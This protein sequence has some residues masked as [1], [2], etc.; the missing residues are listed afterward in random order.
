MTRRPTHITP[1]LAIILLMISCGKDDDKI[2]DLVKYKIS[3]HLTDLYQYDYLGRVI[4]MDSIYFYTYSDSMVKEF[5]E[6]GPHGAD[7]QI[8]HYLNSEGLVYKSV[9]FYLERPT[10]TASFYIDY[11]YYDLNGHLIE[12]SAYRGYVH[13]YNHRYLWE[14]GNIKEKI[15]Q[16]ISP[17]H[18]STS[19]I[20]KYSYYDKLNIRSFG[21]NIFGNKTKNLVK[22]IKKQ[23][24]SYWV[25]YTYEYDAYQRPIKETM[26]QYVSMPFFV[27]T[28]YWQNE[29]KYY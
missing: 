1:F 2:I 13:D 4:Q 21:F 14:G 24:S 26:M 22:E 12:K 23:G 9:G 19:E 5:H 8:N 11:F 27:D 16:D 28:V 10:D 15:I 25:K 18:P 17:N 7:F 29:Y 20:Y 6:G 3:G